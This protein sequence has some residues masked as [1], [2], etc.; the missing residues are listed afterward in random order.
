MYGDNL[1]PGCTIM[2]IERAA[3]GDEDEGAAPGQ[4]GGAEEGIHGMSFG[5][6]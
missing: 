4:R 2:D 3:G 6:C 1:P 5:E